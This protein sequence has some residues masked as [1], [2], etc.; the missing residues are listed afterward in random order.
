MLLIPFDVAD[1]LGG[2]PKLVCKLF[3]RFTSLQSSEN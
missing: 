2:Y 3:W 1:T